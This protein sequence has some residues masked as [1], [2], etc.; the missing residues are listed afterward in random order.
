MHRVAEDHVVEVVEVRELVVVVA[1]SRAVG[2]RPCRG[3]SAHVAEHAE[4]LGGVLARRGRR[5]SAMRARGAK[6]M[7]M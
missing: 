7:R 2:Q 3:T 6:V 1:G 5:S 4:T